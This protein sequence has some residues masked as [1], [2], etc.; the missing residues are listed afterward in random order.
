MQDERG[1]TITRLKEWMTQNQTALK[2]AG[3]AILEASYSG[4][5]DE[6]NFDGVEALSGDELPRDYEVPTEIETLLEALA[7]DLATPGYQNNDGGG[8]QVRLIVDTGMITHE[9]YYYSVERNAD[10]YREF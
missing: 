1:S 8:G 5:G 7:D 6:G 3:V 9:S 10:E 2:G 4:S